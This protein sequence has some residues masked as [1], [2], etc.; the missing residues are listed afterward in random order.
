V[1]VCLI[2]LVS[3]IR[4]SLEEIKHQQYRTLAGRTGRGSLQ[5]GRKIHLLRGDTCLHFLPDDNSNYNSNTEF[6]TLA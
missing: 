4:S 6:I 2:N 5:W 3:T 1:L